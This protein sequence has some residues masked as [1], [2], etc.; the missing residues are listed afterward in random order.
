MR[1]LV[2]L[3]A[4]V[5]LITAG[6][7]GPVACLESIPQ[8]ADM[9]QCCSQRTSGTAPGCCCGTDGSNEPG[10]APADAQLPESRSLVAGAAFTPAATL[11]G[12]D[13]GELTIAAAPAAAAPP[14]LHIVNC[15]FRC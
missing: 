12:D 8:G 10:D 13:A 3:V 11:P 2:G 7:C 15:A 5:A 14:P 9:P 6:F 4:S 1:A